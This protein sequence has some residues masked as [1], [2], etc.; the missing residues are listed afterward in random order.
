MKMA[1]FEWKCGSKWVVFELKCGDFDVKY[2]I[3]VIKSGDFDEKYQFSSQNLFTL[4]EIW[5]FWIKVD[6][7]DTWW[8]VIYDIIWCHITKWCQIMSCDQMDDVRFSIF[9][10][11]N[12]IKIKS[13]KYWMK[14]KNRKLNHLQRGIIQILEFRKF[15]IRKTINFPDHVFQKIH[16][17]ITKFRILK[18]RPILRLVEV[19]QKYFSKNHKNSQFKTLGNF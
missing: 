3:F 5:N 11:S 2:P 17:K 9:S 10:I 13:I 8:Y 7:F 1:I 6:I 18:L 15:Q 16:R 14:Q 4:I 12:W 19:G